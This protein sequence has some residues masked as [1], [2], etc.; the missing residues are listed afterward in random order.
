LSPIGATGGRT[1]LTTFG[2]PG[3]GICG[4][5]GRENHGEIRAG[6]WPSA[7]GGQ[8]FFG[9]MQRWCGK[10]AALGNPGHQN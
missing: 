7:V 2:H 1:F 8:P 3:E 6:K 10:F 5:P 9:I 4:V